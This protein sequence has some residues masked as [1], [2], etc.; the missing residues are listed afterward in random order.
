MKPQLAGQL[1]LLA[2]PHQSAELGVLIDQV[3]LAV[4]VFY[5]RVSARHR[6]I[7]QPDFALV[8]SAHFYARSILHP[9]YVQASLFFRLLSLVYVL[10][11]DVRF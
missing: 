10:Q 8:A 5:L 3:E 4:L 9:N 1:D 11:N 7:L 6:D 2:Q